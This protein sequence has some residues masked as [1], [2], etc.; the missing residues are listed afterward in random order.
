MKTIRILILEDDIKTLSLL[1]NRLEIFEEYGS[2]FDIAVT[3]LS[4]YT[5]VE[6]YINKTNTKFDIILLDR[7]CKACGS[8]H[9]LDFNKFGTDKIISIS[10][11]P[12]WNKEAEARGVKRIVYKDYKQLEEFADQVAKEIKTMLIYK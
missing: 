3:V 7:D 9:V 5:Q 10:S 2:N 1:L 12:E 4:E 8:F 6:E 11:V